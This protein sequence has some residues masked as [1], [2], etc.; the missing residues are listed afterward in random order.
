VLKIAESRGSIEKYLDALVIF[1]AVRAGHGDPTKRVRAA[2]RLFCNRGKAPE[3]KGGTGKQVS[4]LALD[5]HVLIK[6]PGWKIEFR[7]RSTLIVLMEIWFFSPAG[8]KA[9]GDLLWTGFAFALG[10]NI[11]RTLRRFR[12]RPLPDLNV[13][14][15]P[16]GTGAHSHSLTVEIDTIPACTLELSDTRC[17]LETHSQMAMDSR[18]EQ[19]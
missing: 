2:L 19:S 1:W 4:V 16:R 9:Q 17:R 10:R 13:G 8:E 6:P 15:Y 14:F 18:R 11:A 5:P 3:R 12:R 7:K